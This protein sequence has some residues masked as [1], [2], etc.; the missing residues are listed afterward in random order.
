MLSNPEKYAGKRIM[1]MA[2]YSYSFESSGLYLNKEAARIGDIQSAIWVSLPNE[3]G[4]NGRIQKIRRDFVTIIGTFRFDPKGGHGH[5]G[6]WPAEI[7]E[8]TFFRRI[9]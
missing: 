2:Y 3:P 4:R 7:H 8:V 9:K 1:L 5:M 6:V